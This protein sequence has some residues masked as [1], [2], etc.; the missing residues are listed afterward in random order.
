VRVV[1]GPTEGVSNEMQLGVKL[2]GGGITAS[3]SLGRTDTSQSYDLARS[4][5]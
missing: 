2:E 1:V 4:R 5:G 3:A